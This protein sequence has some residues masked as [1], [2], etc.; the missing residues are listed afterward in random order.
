METVLGLSVTSSS[1]GWVVLDGSGTGTAYLD[2]DVVDVTGR[3]ADDLS[4]HIGAVRGA[5]AIAAATG[6]DL[7]SIGVTWTD[8]AAATAK[9]VLRALP[10]LGFDK[11]V[12]IHLADPDDDIELTARAAALAVASS[13]DTVPVPLLRR[14]PVAAAP[15]RKHSWVAPARAAA[16]LVA[17]LSALFVAGPEL[18]GQPESPV[19]KMQ[20]ASDSSAGWQSVYAVSVPVAAPPT[21]VTVQLVAGRPSPAPLRPAA[22]VGETAPMTPQVVEAIAPPVAEVAAPAALL[23]AEPVAVSHLPAQQIAPVPAPTLPAPSPVVSAPDPAQL[24][25]SPLL[26]ALP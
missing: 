20:A 14:E 1:V 5:Q 21:A 24:V 22:T 10:G 4:R 18:A 25:F 26:G 2:H 12:P 23:G 7:T 11:V 16:V 8:D 15:I 9:L 6:Q 13:V 19:P 17:G 3:P